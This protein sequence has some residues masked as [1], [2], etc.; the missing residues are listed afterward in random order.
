LVFGIFE[1][2]VC[3]RTGAAGSVAGSWVVVLVAGGAQRGAR[4]TMVD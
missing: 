1:G 4:R 3:R 2:A